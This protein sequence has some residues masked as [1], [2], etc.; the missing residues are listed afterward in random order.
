MRDRIYRYLKQL[1]DP[2]VAAA[3]WG[4][5]KFPEPPVG[6]GPATSPPGGPSPSGADLSSFLAPPEGEF[7]ASTL[8][9]LEGQQPQTMGEM[10]TQSR[11]ADGLKKRRMMGNKI[12]SQQ[13]GELTYD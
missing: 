4:A 12:T 5:N 8:G 11:F 9:S 1:K 3:A 13:R 7:D 2:D 10:A 6:A